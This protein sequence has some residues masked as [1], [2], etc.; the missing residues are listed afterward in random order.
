[1]RPHFIFTFLLI[2]AALLVQAQNNG[3]LSVKVNTSSTGGNYAPKH[4]MAVW[5]ED[6]NGHFIKTLLA[7]ADKRKKYLN[8]WEASS[9]S[10]G[11]AYNTVDAIT[12]ATKK[13]HATREC[14]WNGTDFSGSE[15]PDGTYK[16]WME[17]TDKNATGNFVSFLFEKGPEPQTLTPEDNP[18]FASVEIVW[19][20]ETTNTISE[21]AE[22]TIIFPNPVNDMLHIP[23]AEV[24]SL[25]IVDQNGKLLKTIQN[26][27]VYLGDLPPGLYFVIIEK[28]NGKIIANRF[29][30]D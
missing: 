2:A 15:T 16:L 7:Y 4:V 26:N 18:S 10:A 3:T 8:T 22:N 1:M 14:S 23:N 25:K 13:S 17:L 12:G 9:T 19:T 28:K 29:I 21:K 6:A 5:I 11:V 27:Q 20:L 24:T 30:K